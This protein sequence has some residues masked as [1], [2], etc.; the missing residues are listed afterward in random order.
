M[1]KKLYCTTAIFEMTGLIVWL[2]TNRYA[3]NTGMLGIV[4]TT[5]RRRR[6]ND[7][8]SMRRNGKCW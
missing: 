7:D 8:W 6:T 4:R 2:L 1:N 5:T 3:W